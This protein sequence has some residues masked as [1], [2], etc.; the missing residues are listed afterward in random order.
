MN[1]AVRIFN[2]PPNL[3]ISNPL[4]NMEAP[5][6]PPTKAC[7]EDDGIPMNQVKRFQ[8]MAAITPAITTVVL[9]AEGLIKSSPTVVATATPKINGAAK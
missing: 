7:E 4:V 6:R 9:I 8:R 3:T 5:R 2:N 1:R